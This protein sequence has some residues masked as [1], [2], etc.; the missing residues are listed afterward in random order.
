MLT[1]DTGQPGPPGPIGAPG[2]DGPEGQRCVTGETGQ[3]VR[4]SFIKFN[5]WLE[6]MRLTFSSIRC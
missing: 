2:Q 5:D 4:K 3:P 1:G 6:L